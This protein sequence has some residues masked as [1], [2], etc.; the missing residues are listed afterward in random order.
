MNGYFV[1]DA[2]MCTALWDTVGTVVRERLAHG[3][4]LKQS[5]RA[6]YSTEMRR[7]IKIVIEEAGRHPGGLS[8]KKEKRARIRKMGEG[9]SVKGATLH[10][11]HLA[12]KDAVAPHSRH[13]PGLVCELS[14]QPYIS[15]R[16][17]WPTVR[18]PH[19]R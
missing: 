19:F 5:V 7:K 3:H 10:F 14:I 8:V 6:A 4:D 2:G 12:A 13:R 16:P 1:Q 17:R 18:S 9:P 15:S 11:L